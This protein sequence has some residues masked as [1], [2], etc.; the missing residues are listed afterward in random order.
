MGYRTASFRSEGPVKK[1]SGQERRGLSWGGAAEQMRKAAGPADS[2]EGPKVEEG[3]SV[4][5]MP[6]WEPGDTGTKSC[7]L[8][9]MPCRQV[10]RRCWSGNQKA[11]EIICQMMQESKGLAV[12]LP[13][14][15]ADEHLLQRALQ[16]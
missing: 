5:R 4:S 8:L 16:P 2:M 14:K 13:H 9:S 15:V 11:Y 12:T 3:R 6:G 10:A 7:P 1:W